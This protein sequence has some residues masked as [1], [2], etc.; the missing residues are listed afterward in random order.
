MLLFQLSHTFR[1]RENVWHSS[2]DMSLDV[3]GLPLRGSDQ[4]KWFDFQ[5]VPES[6]SSALSLSLLLILGVRRPAS[7]SDPSSSFLL[8]LH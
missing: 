8:S 5:R 3:Q 7:G 2:L 6:L 1:E 4:A